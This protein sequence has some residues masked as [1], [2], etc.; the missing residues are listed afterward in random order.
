MLEG[1]YSI[2]LTLFVIIILLMLAMMFENDAQTLILTPIEQMM[3]MINMV[4]DDPLEEFDFEDIGGGTPQYEL[5][6]VILAIQKITSLLRIGFGEAGA[7][8]ISK[9]MSVEGGSHNQGLDPMIPGKR[10]YVAPQGFLLTPPSNSLPPLGTPSSASA[11]STS[12]T[13]APRCSRTRSWRS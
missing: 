4:A 7:E 5:K 10:M 6:V 13:C 3:S 11:T 8:I 1:Q 9:N 2:Y 12:S